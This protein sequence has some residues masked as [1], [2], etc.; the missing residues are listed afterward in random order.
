MTA[1]PAPAAAPPLPEPRRSR[2]RGRRER[3][4]VSAATRRQQARL[5]VLLV[6]PAVVLMAVFLVFPVLNAV[7]YV[8]VDFDGLDTTPPWVGLANFTELA[9]D[10]QMWAAAWNNVIWIV[11]GTAGPLLLGTGLA[12]LL[13]GVRRGS[14]FYRVVF[15]LPYVLPQVAVG[16]VWGWIYAPTRGWLN[17]GLEAVGLGGVTRGWLGDPDT[18]LFAVLGTAIWTATG[19]VFVIV[20]SALRNVATEL[21]DAA[22]LDGANYLQRLRYVVMPQIMPV[23]LMVTALTL[24]GGFAVFDI[25]F[26][27][28]G[29]GPANATE[30]LGTYAYSNAFQLSRISYGTTLALV[31]TA[32]AVPV[33]VWLNRLQRRASGEGLGA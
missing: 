24:I 21:V 3:S 12:L 31:V 25:V 32:L 17:R 20:L 1:A 33:A 23:F 15:F 22:M 19:F 16:V 14:T 8:F 28:T 7:Y 29:G 5:G 27:M 2:R 26:V 11:L 9:Q 10:R 4:G 30:V 13:W 6:A 18:A